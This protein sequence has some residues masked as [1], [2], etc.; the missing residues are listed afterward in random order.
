MCGAGILADFLVDVL[1]FGKLSMR[2]IDGLCS[3]SVPH[4]T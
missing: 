2:A 4:V 1:E 3:A